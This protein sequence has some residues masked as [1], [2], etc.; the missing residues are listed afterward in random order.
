MRPVQKSLRSFLLGL[1]FVAAALE[2]R[3]QSPVLADGGYSR[4][5]PKESP[6]RQVPIVPPGAGGLDRF[7]AHC[8]SCGLCVSACKSQ[9]LR[10]SSDL[11]HFL[12]P[13]VSYEKG[14]CRPECTACSQ[15]CP[16][17][18][19]RPLDVV[20]KSSVQVGHAVWVKDRC[21]PL[22]DNQDCGLCARRCPAEAILM[23][24]MDPHDPESR[25][26]P[27]IDEAKCTGCGRCESLCP[28]NPLSAIY[29]E[30][31]ERHRII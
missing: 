31:H 20:L 15:V 17:G 7:H 19:I 3:A 27:A 26:V 12:Q 1:P 13:E 5:I 2:S 6:V 4:L 22:R 8:T 18:A 11:R 21:I 28:S 24:P 25:K 23:V 10:P 16:S 14:Y 30:G 29:V 9:V